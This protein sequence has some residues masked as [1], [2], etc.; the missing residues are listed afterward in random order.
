MRRVSAESSKCEPNLTPLL[1]V[2]LQLLMFFILCANFATAQVAENIKLPVMHSARPT[3]KKDADL[4]YLNLR[5]DGRVEMLGKDATKKPAI[6]RSNLRTY[7]DDTLR[8]QGT[9]R[10]SELK[11]VIVLR[12]DKNAEYKDVFQLLNWCKEL[13]YRKYQIRAMTRHERTKTPPGS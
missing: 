9:D 7:R 10:L 13:G 6:I 1:D 8:A 12:A 3:D 4:L 11:T 2:V 5:Q